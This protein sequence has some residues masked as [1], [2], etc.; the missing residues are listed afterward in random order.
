MRKMRGRIKPEVRIALEQEFSHDKHLS[1]GEIAYL[2]GK[3]LW[4]E[5]L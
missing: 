2:S 4:I 1:F 3:L 5:I